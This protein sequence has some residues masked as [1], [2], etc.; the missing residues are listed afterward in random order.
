M[1]QGTTFR[2]LYKVQLNRLELPRKL[3]M[4]TFYKSGM[5]KNTASI[6][7]K[8]SI[9]KSESCVHLYAIR[10]KDRAENDV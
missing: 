5:E 6:S 2:S 9:A 3:W 7:T 8:S 4:I 1:R 10:K